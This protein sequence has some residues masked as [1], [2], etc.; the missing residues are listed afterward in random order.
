MAAPP[1]LTC[2]TPDSAPYSSAAPTDTTLV[3]A[4]GPWRQPDLVAL[5]LVTV[6]GSRWKLS[7]AVSTYVHVVPSGR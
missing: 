4:A 1:P 7:G 5:D 3:P 2:P 6:I